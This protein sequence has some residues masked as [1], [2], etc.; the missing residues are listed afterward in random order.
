V[1]RLHAIARMGRR[2]LDALLPRRTLHEVSSLPRFVSDW[3]HYRQL[4]HAERLRLADAAPQLDDRVPLT[5]FDPHYLYQAAWATER[6]VAEA[7]ERHVDVASHAM[8][9]GPL[10]VHVPVTFVD[11]RPL[12]LDLP[13]FTS[14][15]GDVTALPFDTAEIQSLSCLHVAEHVGLGRY[16]DELDPRG[17]RRACAELARVLSPG[18]SLYF[19]LPVGRSRV[20]FNAHRIHSPAEILEYFSELSLTEFA[21]VGDDGRLHLDAAPSDA[22]GLDYGCGLFRFRRTDQTRA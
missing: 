12:E 18:G 8:F 19:S 21:F 2:A 22:E 10:S 11:I 13:G 20:C 14:T 16:G 9:V 15:V 6:I 4:P 5:P 1:T 3:R 17:T 7:P